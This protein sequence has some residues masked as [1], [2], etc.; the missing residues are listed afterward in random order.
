MATRTESRVVY[1]AGVSQGIVL[2]TFPAASTVFTDPA[3]YDLSNT[4]YGSLFVPQVITAIAA[5]LLGA[6]LAGRFGTKRVYL[7]GLVA[8]LVSMVVLIV[9][10]F[11]T[12]DQ[13]AA[14][15]LLLFATA[16]LGVGFGLSVPALNTFAA[17]FHPEAVDRAILVLNALLG[18]GTVLAPVFAA[19]FVGLG[20]W[21]GLPVTSAG[22][23][24]ALIFVSI[25]LPLRVEARR[26]VSVQARIA[27]PPRLWVYA[28]FAVVYGVCETVNG[29][30]S[31]LD[32]TSE[33]GASRTQASLALTAFWAMVTLG[34]VL[35][36]AVQRWLPSR[37]TYHVLPFLLA[38]AF[39]IIA[40]LPDDQP[41]L[42]VL[43]FGLAGL[44][45][46]ALLP[47][48]ISFGQEELRAVAAT[49]AGGVIACYQ[50]GYGI[51]AFGIGP[52][53]DSGVGLPTI[54]GLSAVIA[55]V[56]GAWSFVVARRRPSPASLH[57]HLGHAAE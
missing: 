4:Q 10:Q 17:A 2:V 55:L 12:D 47:L 19:I 22:L 43:A 8:A 39:V 34:R 11:L 23:L 56:M 14:Y 26:P 9:S 20:F 51:A 42:G 6:G 30:W 5:A 57:P 16:C 32:M 41:A 31:Q 25:R 52:L 48:T 21:W 29:N 33:L 24:V 36:A 7:A 18:L 15:A 27:I 37:M 3:Q 45:C 13:T 38:G 1:A 49:V 35:F 53:L 44:G 40:V 46:S 54:Y 28:G 50:L